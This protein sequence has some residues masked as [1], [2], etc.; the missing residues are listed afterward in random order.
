MWFFF[1]L[2]PLIRLLSNRLKLG[3]FLWFGLIYRDYFHVSE[4]LRQLQVLNCTNLCVLLAHNGHLCCNNDVLQH[5]YVLL[6]IR[7]LIIFVFSASSKKKVIVQMMRLL[8]C[9]SSTTLLKRYAIVGFNFWQSA[10]P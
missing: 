1:Q 4:H 9:C 7:S 6:C 2:C 8:R 5:Y 3:V 10:V